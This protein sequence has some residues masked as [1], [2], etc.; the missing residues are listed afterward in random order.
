MLQ[1]VTNLHGMPHQTRQCV[2]FYTK[3][4]FDTPYI[5]TRITIRRPS[6]LRYYDEQNTDRATRRNSI[7]VNAASRGFG[8]TPSSTQKKN[9]KS[10]CPCG[11]GRSYANCCKKYHTGEKL[12][13]TAEGLMRSRYTA[14]AKGLVDYVVQTTHPDNPAA[15][16][17]IKTLRDDVRATC[18]KITWDKLVILEKE[19]GDEDEAFVTFKTYFKVVGQRGQRAQGFHTQSFIE[20]S[21]F[22]RRSSDGAWSYV[23]GEQEWQQ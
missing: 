11:S 12:P 14:Y 4:R 3:T 13:D 5:T 2:D 23:D 8:S 10:S 7:I 20:R 19:S 22:L 18:D 21:R 1:A 17:D 9:K 16:E 6:G 15:K